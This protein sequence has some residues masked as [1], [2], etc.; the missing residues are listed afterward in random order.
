MV[1]NGT[2]T[3]T[4]TN[5]DNTGSTVWAQDKADG[6]KITASRHDTHDQDLADGI[7]ACLPVNGEKAMTG[8]LPMGGNSITGA[9]QINADVIYAEGLLQVNNGVLALS[10]SSMS[11]PT[12]SKL[13][14]LTTPPAS[15]SATGITGQMAADSNYIYY[16][17]ATNTWKRVAI[18]TW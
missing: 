16:C 13:I 14:L 9:D 8:D 2:G 6:D 4:R 3:F 1:W 10:T 17:T 15:A 12:T 5:G 11:I 7:N 18:S